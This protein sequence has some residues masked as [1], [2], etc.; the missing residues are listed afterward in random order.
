MRKEAAAHIRPIGDALYVFNGRG[1]AVEITP[2]PSDD[3][4]K[5]ILQALAEEEAAKGSG[6]RAASPEAW[7]DPRIVEP[8]D[9]RQN[10]RYE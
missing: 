3:E 9:P 10:E 4:R 8:G 6:R 2:E 5:A 7:G 1:M